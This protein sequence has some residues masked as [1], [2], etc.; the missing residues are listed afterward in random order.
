MSPAEMNTF[1]LLPPRRPLQGDCPTSFPYRSR[2]T[3]SP[4]AP[5][6]G[7][8]CSGLCVPCA[9]RPESPAGTSA[10]VAALHKAFYA[11]RLRRSGSLRDLRVKSL[12]QTCR[13]HLRPCGARL[14]LLGAPAH[15]EEDFPGFKT[16]PG[17]KSSSGQAPRGRLCQ[18]EHDQAPARARTD[19]RTRSRHQPSPCGA[20]PFRRRKGKGW[21]EKTNA[22]ILL[23]LK[24][25]VDRP[26]QKRPAN[27]SVLGQM[28]VLLASAPALPRTDNEIKFETYRYYLHCIESCMRAQYGDWE[29]FVKFLNERTKTMQGF[30]NPDRDWVARFLKI[31]WN[32]EYLLFEGPDD[33]ELIRMNNQW[34]PIQAYYALYSCAEAAGYLI[35]GNKPDGHIK[36]LRKISEYFVRQGFA[37]WCLSFCGCLGKDKE[38]ARA[39]HFPADLQIPH[40]LSRTGIQPIQMV[41]KCLRA[42][43]ANR[44]DDLFEKGKGLYKYNFDPGHT[45]ILH[46]MYRLRIKSNYKDVEIFLAQAPEKHIVGF[47]KSINVIVGWSMSYMEILIARKCKKRFLLELAGEYLALNKNAK[48]LKTRMD[49]YKALV[50]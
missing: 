28:P 32:T 44:V 50:N 6:R 42:E 45:T 18:C 11:N 15:P 10:A 21:P 49:K 3:G 22:L 5:F 20:L 33:P 23:E 34:K 48:H 24:T 30:A 14:G 8:P 26:W 19:V 47:N 37:P 17:R 40:N 9:P 29:R 12:M 39:N 7:Q 46:F 4:A 31:A 38:L 2:G 27:N 1:H 25:I 16:H 13:F 41:A 43:H 35:D 36:A